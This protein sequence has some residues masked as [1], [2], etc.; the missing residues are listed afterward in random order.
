MEPDANSTAM[1]TRNAAQLRAADQRSV[2]RLRVASNLATLHDRTDAERI[3]LDKK[4]I[5]AASARWSSPTELQER[6]AR[7]KRELA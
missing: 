3:A 6:L 7:L 2:L 4:R 1:W 5:A